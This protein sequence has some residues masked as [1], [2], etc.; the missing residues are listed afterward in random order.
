VNEPRLVLA[1]EPTGNLDSK[2]SGEILELLRDLCRDGEVP[3]LL[4]THDPQAREFV[5]SVYTLRD[6]RVHEG[7]D[8]EPAVAPA[9]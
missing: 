3:G 6:G 7:L 4:V 5:S 8:G 9:P 2:R 1:D